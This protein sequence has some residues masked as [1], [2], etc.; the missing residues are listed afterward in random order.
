MA[1][2]ATVVGGLATPAYATAPTTPGKPSA[3]PAGAP[4]GPAQR[5][6]ARAKQTGRPV[7][8]DELTT[9]NST[10]AANPDG[11]FTRTQSPR[12]TRIR[13][14]GAWTD[15]DPTLRANAD[16]T[17]SP[18]ATTTG[19]TLS[20]GGTAPL[21]AFQDPA[22]HHLA[23]SLP[24]AL[25][26]PTVDG[27]TATYTGVLP[28]VDLEV[29]VTDQGAFRE[30]LVVKNA[31]AAANPALRTLRLATSTNGL[32]TS[33]DRDGNLTVRAADGSTAFQLPTP[34]MWDSAHTTGVVLP[35][36]TVVL[37]AEA[38]PKSARAAAAEADRATRPV[39]V[40]AA[41]PG[42]VDPADALSSSKAGPGRGAHISKLDVR[43]DD[44]SISLVPDPDRL[45][46]A[47]YP[48]F[49]DPYVNPW[50]SGTNS[51]TE[52]KEGCPSQT[53]YNV[54]QD[55][56][57][58]IGYQQYDPNCAG[59][60]RSYY[61]LDTRWLNSSMVLQK[62]VLTFTETY[63]AD[64]G[65]DNTWEA[66]LDF[67]R[68]F[69][70][71]TSWSNQP[72][73]AGNLGVQTPKS[74]YFGCGNRSVAF[75]ITSTLA[76][77]PTYPDFSFMLR[78]NENKYSTNYGFMRFGTNPTLVTDFDVAPQVPV[79]MATS[80]ASQNPSTT[81]CGS[82]APGW[83]GMT[84]LNGNASNITLSAQ[85][86][87]QMNG[88]NLQGRFHVWDNSMNGGG[89]QPTDWVY[90][91][92]SWVGNNPGSWT[93]VSAN[94][95][96]QVQD[97]H[98]YGWD[99]QATDGTLSSAVSPYCHFKVDLT[100]PSLAT[101]ADSTAFPPLG[102]G[103][104][105]TAHAGD[106][107]VSIAVSSV[108]PIPT[109]CTNGANG[110]C[111]ASGV[112]GFQWA[113][114]QN[115]P[116]SGAN[117][118]AATAG[119]GTSATA[120][121]PINLT[122]NQWGTH[123]LFVRAVDNA[124][125]TQATA[126]AYSF[127]APWNSTV[128]VVA[129]DLTGDG[130]PDLVT[131]G[132]DDNLYLVKGNTDLGSAPELA[133][134]A[135]GSPNQLGWSSFLVTHRGSEVQGTVDDLF[136]L[137]N[138]TPKAMY[139][140]ANDG[141]AAAPA[142]GSSVPG[143]FNNLNVQ[144]LTKPAAC[145]GSCTGYSSS[146]DAVTQ[147]VAPGAF[148]RLPTWNALGVNP[149]A[150]LITVENGKLW[151]YPGSAKG[152]ANLS[153]PYLISSD[154]WSNATLIAPGTV[155]GSVNT[156]AN[157]PTTQGGTPTLWAR[158]NITG[159]VN[160]YTLGFDPGTGTPAMSLNAPARG[161][162][163]SGVKATG[164]G[165]LCLDD[166]LAAT[167]DGTK[168]QV[169]GCN[170]SD[171]QSLTV[172]TDNSIHLKGKC[173]DVS[174]GGTGNGNPVQL[175][176]C[177]NST[178]QKWVQPPGSNEWQNP[179]SGRCLADPSDSQSPG[180]QLVIEDCS[181]T[182]PGQN[183]AA[184]AGSAAPPVQAVL[185]LGAGTAA[186][187]PTV[188]SAGDAHQSGNPDLYLVDGTG[189]VAAFAGTA[190]DPKTGL[191]QFGNWIPQALGALHTTSA[192]LPL[193]GQSGGQ[194]ADLTGQHP[195]TVL[196]GVSF[197]PDTV[198]NAAT[199][200]AEFPGTAGSEIDTAGTA[201]DTGHS[202][203]FSVM[204]KPTTGSTGVVLSQDGVNGSGFILWADASG[205]WRF[206]MARSDSSGWDYD[207]TVDSTN[208]AALAVKVGA[209]TRLAGSYDAASGRTN[210]WVNGVL[211][212]TGWHT[213]QSGI[214]GPLVIGRDKYAGNPN[215][216]F[217]GAVA[218]LTVNDYAVPV[219]GGP[220]ITSGVSPKCL[221]NNNGSPANGNHVQV[222]DCSGYTPGAAGQ[223]WSLNANGTLTNAG[224][225]L[226]AGGAGTLN[227]TPVDVWACN[228][229]GNQRWI[230][231]ADGSLLNPASGRC[232]A[233]PAAS[234]TNGTQ[235]ILWDCAS[236]HPEQTWNVGGLTNA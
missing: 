232:L 4:D 56:G 37:G 219:S 210:L 176:H 128:H 156:A 88:V 158:N 126:A 184:P 20:G 59:L 72:Y 43:A 137:K 227:G 133:S 150:D 222:W 169:Y 182:D 217:T 136:A 27:S 132:T 154:D 90:P 191:A 105:A 108:D 12:P 122:P 113:L 168:V 106:S 22:G 34:V 64:H 70:G 29:H 18:V 181:G 45:A 124:G 144:V 68:S 74:A 129:G 15:L 173:L 221:D 204:A 6:R 186:D 145:A 28:D 39:P 163:G 233:D 125:N 65:C 127:Y 170:G 98:N 138:T 82:G 121:I 55:N 226:D 205:V 31:A 10:L 60:Y 48:V 166:A 46:D 220:R 102:S 30:V 135:A 17:L 99:V 112:A 94:I 207:Y 116:V 107:G 96:G 89:G 177:N 202:F 231:R 155:G 2:L 134:T 140:Y 213:S 200:V 165:A 54:A 93:T 151:Y 7:T 149:Y 198:N 142:G 13:R 66:Y 224:A 206:V 194:T 42:A 203:S 223:Q 41:P 218:D 115:I 230:P 84:T 192:N 123:T 183:W 69:D 92:S 85:L 16:G 174:G 111:D 36:N 179:Y 195:G 78:G 175:W 236:G 26:R 101:F 209:W 44:H 120:N 229:G 71:N 201:I 172:G 95:G 171:A 216:F 61:D 225:C 104:P 9:E 208:A 162:L 193:A 160:Q 235:L 86:N 47:V 146:W 114:D 76:A 32:T 228:G 11:S 79:S 49:V 167:Q 24:F 212:G 215:A 73:D 14:N 62:S 189:K 214:S 75:D 52:V 148:S 33:A 58:A 3:A 196:G 57:E 157:P 83:I 161:F 109:G 143:H 185:A 97:G 5:A 234:T 51:Y 53:L 25:P 139:L 8:V 1:T 87:S 188:L 50:S 141:N 147:M 131:P 38:A 40:S 67:T 164:G 117:Y 152:G 119:S 110:A 81:A 103:R 190:P 35:Q 180:T 153:A 211:A 91:T 199:T 197:G 19:V 159:A 21:A 77:H 63:G 80:P 178:A 100:P 118:A 23:L 187:Y 130:V